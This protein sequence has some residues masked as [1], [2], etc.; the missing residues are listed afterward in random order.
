[1]E[2]EWRRQKEQEKVQEKEFAVCKEKAAEEQK[3]IRQIE[4]MENGKVNDYQRILQNARRETLQ[5]KDLVCQKKESEQASW[6]IKWTQKLAE[7]VSRLKSMQK[8]DNKRN[9]ILKRFQSWRYTLKER[10]RNYHFRRGGRFGTSGKDIKTYIRFLQYQQFF[11]T[12]QFSHK[13]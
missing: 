2:A 1:M 10:S 5:E 8:K 3:V 4:L 13:K 6:N 12:I 11:I 7:E 9:S